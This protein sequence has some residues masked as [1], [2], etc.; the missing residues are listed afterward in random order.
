MTNFSIPESNLR[1][2]FDGNVRRYPVDDLLEE[3]H[4]N[5]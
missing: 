5:V 1:G 2:Y 3:G 4:K